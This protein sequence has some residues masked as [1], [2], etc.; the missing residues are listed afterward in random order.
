MR[1]DVSATLFLSE[2]EDYD[3][4]ELTI[5]DTYGAP[6]PSKLPA[7]DLVISTRRPACTA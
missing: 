5:D 7:S 6:Y 1:T 3:D 2:P 4:G